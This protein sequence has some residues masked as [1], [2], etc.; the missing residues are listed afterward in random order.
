M[1]LLLEQ[2]QKNKIVTKIQIVEIVI[3]MGSSL[4]P[5]CDDGLYM[6]KSSSLSVSSS[7]CLLEYM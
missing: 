5:G 4:S 2:H 7:T 1:V 3:G 6:E